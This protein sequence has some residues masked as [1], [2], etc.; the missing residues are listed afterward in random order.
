[1]RVKELSNVSPRTL[2]VKVGEQPL[3]LHLHEPSLHLLRDRRS[4]PCAERL[5]R[6]NYLHQLHFRSPLRVM[7]KNLN[8]RNLRGPEEVKCTVPTL[9]KAVSRLSKGYQER[10]W[11]MMLL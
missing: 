7:A 9:K 4:R 5:K 2:S 8:H 6:I 10:S 1:M 3:M 11:R